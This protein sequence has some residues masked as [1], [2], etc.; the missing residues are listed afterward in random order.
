MNKIVEKNNTIEELNKIVEK[1]NTIEELNEIVEKNNTIEELNEIVEKNNAIEE[2]NEIVEKNNTIEEL[3]EIAEKFNT[4]EELTEIINVLENK[5]GQLIE[6][7]F[8]NKFNQLRKLLKANKKPYKRLPRHDDLINVN[9]FYLFKTKYACRSDSFLIGFFTHH[10]NFNAE[11]RIYKL[12]PINPSEIN[13]IENT[14][15]DLE[16]DFLKLTEFNRGWNNVNFDFI[17]GH[18]LLNMDMYWKD[19]IEMYKI[20]IPRD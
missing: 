20:N 5:K 15:L 10:P 4:I 16:K 9:S 12:H 17:K 14:D 18:Y 3:N 8:N 7:E 13:G 6:V 2:L 1:N 19:T 11:N